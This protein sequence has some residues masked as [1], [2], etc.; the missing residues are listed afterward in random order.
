VFLVPGWFY[1]THGDETG[2]DF[3]AQRQTLGRMRIANRLVTLDE[4]GTVEDNAKTVANA[5][6]E[7]STHH[8]IL[9]VS[10]SKSGPEV[11]QALGRELDQAASRSVVGWV[12]IGGVV[13][14]SPI[15]DRVLEPAF[16]WFTELK[17][18]VEGF[19]LE[20]AKSMR[21]NRAG[22]LFQD[23][24]FPSHVRIV[25]FVPTPL[26]GDITQRA[27]SAMAV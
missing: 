12:S 24:L 2:A 7:E 22:K 5:I 18:G 26:S 11:A 10:A 4:N 14:G 27:N 15:A 1:V 16:C 20:S 9:L 19:N 17:F 21:T 3:M 25:C 23:L 8:Q 13:R 6:R